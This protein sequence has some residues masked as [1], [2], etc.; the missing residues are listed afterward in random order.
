MVIDL[1]GLL[2]DVYLLKP[3]S[4]KDILTA[5]LL[6][7]ALLVLPNH[8]FTCLG[9][10]EQFLTSLYLLPVPLLLAFALHLT[11]QGC[12]HKRFDLLVAR[13]SELCCEFVFLR[14]KMGLSLL[15]QSLLLLLSS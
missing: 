11:L 7:R 8:D 10:L 9:K 14:S 13:L 15:L 3:C 2:I 4:S 6:G 5:I 1:F 12:G